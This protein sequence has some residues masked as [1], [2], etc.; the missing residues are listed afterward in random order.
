MLRNINFLVLYSIKTLSNLLSIRQER[1]WKAAVTVREYFSEDLLRLKMLSH[2]TSQTYYLVWLYGI[3]DFF[4][5]ISLRF[6][7][8]YSGN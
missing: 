3:L 7:I 4:S 2:N 5:R 8:L 1:K 6:T